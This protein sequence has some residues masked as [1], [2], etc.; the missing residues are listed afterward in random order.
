MTQSSD[1]K[2]YSFRDIGEHYVRTLALWRKAF[3]KNIKEVKALGF[4]DSFIRMWH[5]YLSYCEG[6][7]KEK[8]I[9]DIHLKLIKPRYRSK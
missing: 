8:A 6:G 3:F 1:L 2:I 7:F 5:F 4:D 9:S